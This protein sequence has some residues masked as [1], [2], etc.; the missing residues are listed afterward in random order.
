MH[1][2]EGVIKGDPFYLTPIPNAKG[3]VWYK[4][5]AI[6]INTLATTVRRLCEMAGISGYKAN[7]SLSVTTVTRLFH[8]GMDEQLIMERT[9]HR[10]TD[11]VRAYKRSCLEQQ[12]L[13]SRVFN[14]EKVGSSTFYQVTPAKSSD[15][16]S[17]SANTE[18]R[19]M[20]PSAKALAVCSTT[21]SAGSEGKGKE[22]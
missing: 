10:S 2:P 11:G 19:L 7:H 21:E 8:S 17:T 3:L 1:R 9:G 13:V 4:K 20:P 5:Q 14:R 18:L 12:A 16:C 22:N 15:L 6:A